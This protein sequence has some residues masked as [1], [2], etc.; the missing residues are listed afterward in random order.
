MKLQLSYNSRDHMDKL[1]VKNKILEYY[2]N[3]LKI[4]RQAFTHNKRQIGYLMKELLLSCTNLAAQARELTAHV[5]YSF[6]IRAGTVF[7]IPRL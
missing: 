4:G 7:A 6:H 2:G 1:E 3:V 5:H